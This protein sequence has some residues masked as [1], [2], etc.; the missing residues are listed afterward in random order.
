MMHL[1]SRYFRSSTNPPGWKT[2]HKKR[3][4]L[5]YCKSRCCHMKI[6]NYERLSII[7]CKALFLILQAA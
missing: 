6:E 3:R 7:R 5:F 4:G 1:F 2:F